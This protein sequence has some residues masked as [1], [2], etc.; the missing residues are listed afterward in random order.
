MAGCCWRV[1][2]PAD[3]LPF[4][5]MSLATRCPICEALFRVTPD[6]LRARGGQ[7]RCGRC[8]AVFDGLARLA[9]DL[10]RGEPPGDLHTGAQEAAP[11]AENEAP[12]HVAPDSGGAPVDTVEAAAASAPPAPD[13]PGADVPA[14]ESMRPTAPAGHDFLADEGTDRP[15]WTKQWPMAA[16]SVLLAVLLA[17][18]LALRDRD[19][20]AA[21]HPA[22]RAPLAAICSVLGCELG[23]PRRA[24]RL[25]IEG[26]EMIGADPAEP[27]RVTLIATLRNAAEFAVAY[28]HLELALQNDQDQVLA[29]RTLGPGDYLER[30]TDQVQGI[31]AREEVNLRLAL[32]TG[33]LRADGYRLLVYY[34]PRP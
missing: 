19:E 11:S 25:S 6:Q 24:D 12:P 34:P 13:V 33:T 18:Q 15:S 29:R 32:D 22:L 27:S 9:Q 1:V 20:L 26:D 30:G 2:E 17:F 5:S 23:L 28:P 10:D 8:N 14:S 3:F 21:K 7:V 16:V 4:A 31:A